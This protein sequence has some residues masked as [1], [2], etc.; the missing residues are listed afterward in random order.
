LRGRSRFSSSYWRNG[1][2]A[3]LLVDPF[4]LVVHQHAV[5]VERD[6]QLVV[7]FVVHGRAGQHVAG[8]IAQTHRL[9]HLFSDRAQVERRVDGFHER[10][11][12]AAGHEKRPRDV[13]ARLAHGR[14]HQL[15]VVAW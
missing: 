12:L 9:A 14:D 2:N 5:E 10:V 8:G 4:G 6:A 13:L 11:R 3:G 7:L 15:A 1:R